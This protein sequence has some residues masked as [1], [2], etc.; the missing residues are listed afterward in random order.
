MKFV[1][2]PRHSHITPNNYTNFTNSFTYS[3]L[4]F[5]PTL[6]INMELASGESMHGNKLNMWL[7]RV[8]MH[9][10]NLMTLMMQVS[11]KTFGLYGNKIDHAQ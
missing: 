9:N 6:I 4:P 1:D 7:H 8:N 10:F 5:S 3:S 11:F 2:T